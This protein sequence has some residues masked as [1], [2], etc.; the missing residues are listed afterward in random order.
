MTDDTQAEIEA[1]DA[2]RKFVQE[3]VVGARKLVP[4]LPSHR[5]TDLY[6]QLDEALSEDLR[7]LPEHAE[8]MRKFEAGLTEPAAPKGGG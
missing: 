4:Q 2:I 6:Y 8:E 7:E 1:E 3:T 5:R